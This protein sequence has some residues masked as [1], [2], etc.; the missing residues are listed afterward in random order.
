METILEPAP[1]PTG[2]RRRVLYIVVAA[3]LAAGA[4]GAWLLQRMGPRGAHA[5]DAGKTTY[6]CPM[7][8][9]YKSDRP[10]NCPICSMKLVPLETTP[11][12]PGAEAGAPGTGQ[13]PAA[14]GGGALA[15]RITPERQQQ[16]GVRFAEV[17]SQQAAVEIR[18][19]GKVAYDETQL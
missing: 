1:R 2:G 14:A 16:I 19:V 18:A 5:E 7:H 6:Y 17:A 13:A 4:G 10:G 8:T 9:H 3:L 15:I 11:A 12:A